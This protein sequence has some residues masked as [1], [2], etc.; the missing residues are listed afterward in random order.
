MERADVS[1]YEDKV[2]IIEILNLYAFALDSH[3]LGLV[4]SNFYE[5]RKGRFWLS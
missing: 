5:R 2:E 1:E 4:R 3:Q